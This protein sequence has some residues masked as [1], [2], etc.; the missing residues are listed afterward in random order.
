VGGWPNYGGW[1]GTFSICEGSGCTPGAQSTP[2][3]KICVDGQHLCQAAGGTAAGAYTVRISGALDGLSNSGQ[4]SGD[5]TLT[6][7]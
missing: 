7:K 4:T 5:I 1:P 2:H 3:F 6:G